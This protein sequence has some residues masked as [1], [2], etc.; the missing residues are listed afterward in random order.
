LDTLNELATA[1]ADDS[2]FASTV[3]GQLAL[4]ASIVYVDTALA[5]KANQ[6]TTYTKTAVD[7]L[8]TPKLTVSYLNEQLAL[9]A[10]QATTYTKTETDNLLATEQATITSATNLTVNKLITRNIDPPPAGFTDISLNANEAYLRNPVWLS[11]TS[12]A[13]NFWSSVYRGQGLKVPNSF[14]I[15]YQSSSIPNTATIAQ[16]GN[17]TTQATITCVGNLSA[18]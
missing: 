6:S 10:T 3:Q 12:A 2:N 4:K 8:L 7:N 18:P 13:V 16:N 14:A 17:I 15:G 11:T 5:P 9:K 1:L